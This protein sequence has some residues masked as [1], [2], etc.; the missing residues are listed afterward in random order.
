MEKGLG[1]F[2]GRHKREREPFWVGE[3]KKH[4]LENKMGH[5]SFYMCCACVVSCVFVFSK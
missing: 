5:V 1:G 3:R 2:F 4:W